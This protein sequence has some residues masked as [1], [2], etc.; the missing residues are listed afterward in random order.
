MNK[1]FVLRMALWSALIVY[2]ACDFFLLNGPLKRELRS[3]FPTEEDQYHQAIADGIC[4]KVYNQPIFLS[5]VD[6]RV[7]EKLYRTGRALDQVKPKE[8]SLLRWAAMDELISENLLRIK[9]KANGNEVPV[10]DEEID[11][12]LQRFENRFSS[13]EELEQ[14]MVVQGIESREELRYRMAARL[15]QE[16]YLNTKIQ[17]SIAVS[18]KEAKEWYDTHQEEIKML[19]RRNVRHVFLATLDHP[20]EEAKATLSEH[21]TKLEAKETD[22][23]KLASEVSEDERSKTQGGELGWVRKKRLPGDFAAHVFTMPVNKPTLVRTKLGWHI[24]EVTAIKAPE[25]PPFDQLQDEI[26]SALSDSKRKEAI[27]Q[28]QHQVRLLNHKKIEII[29]E[30]INTPWKQPSATE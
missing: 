17:K 26:V 8:F 4:A 6:R 12:E 28:Y 3:M 23:A 13:K 14:A 16:K 21:L 29:A 18:P 15:Q 2:L 1:S 5:Q 25:V 10:S 7:Q 20:S 11:A 24:L 19:E 9:T 22:F 27:R 30:V